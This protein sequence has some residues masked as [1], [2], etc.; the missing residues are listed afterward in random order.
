MTSRPLISFFAALGV[1]GWIFMKVLKSSGSNSK[2]AFAA[3]AATFVVVFLVMMILT[4]I[5]IK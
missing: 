3:G 4:G 5:F 2:S 1:A